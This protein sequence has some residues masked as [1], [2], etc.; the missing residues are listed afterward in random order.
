MLRRV[1]PLRRAEI[2][3]PVLLVCSDDASLLERARVLVP[4]A[5]QAGQRG[6]LVE[7]AT[8]GASVLIDLRRGGGHEAGSVSTLRCEPALV[9]L[10]I[11]ALVSDDD[12][13][14]ARDALGAGASDFL[15]DGWLERDLVP[16]LAAQQNAWRTRDELRLRERD[17][18]TLVELTRSFAGALDAGA[19]LHD[20]T[21]R[22]AEELALRRCS[23]V[24]TDAR[25]ERGTVVATSDD[26]AIARRSIEL[27]KYP[28]IREA[29]RTR[30]AVVVHDAGRH[31]LLDPVKE[32]VSAAGMGAMAV[33]PLALEEEIL[34][35]LFLRTPAG[36][37]RSF[38]SRELDFAAAVANATAVALRN[39]R[40]VAE[41]RS[42]VREA[43]EQAAT[44]R[45]YE[46]IYEHV[47]DGIALV[48]RSS[49]RLRS[50]N[51]AALGI[52]GLD[53]EAVRGRPM[54]ELL[55]AA[56]GTPW[57][58]LVAGASAGGMVRNVEFPAIR[59]DGPEVHLAVS[60][61]SLDEELV[62]L[63]IRDVTERKRV[64]QELQ[65]TRENLEKRTMIVELAGAA[66][67]ELNQPLTSV[68]GWAELLQ[69]RLTE[70][71][72]AQ[73][74]VS[75]ILREAERMAEVVRKIGNITRHET[76]AYVGN[77]RILD[78]EKAAG[79]AEEGET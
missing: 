61:S 5:V 11:L 33:L 9:E 59:S 50:A 25:G 48:D 30:R 19:L 45:R 4:L 41:I 39:A 78:L 15:R 2:E 47:S 7:R 26:E 64:E 20:V 1:S 17:L 10:P 32:A 29:L 46:E 63:A 58:A 68:L 60:A 23:L 67:H 16:R 3:K 75:I 14:A 56:E 37:A 24:L 18:H 73:R 52:L 40:S 28:E 49:G 51:P 31:P 34:G 74:P 44:L 38:S 77:A 66:A 43:E 71:D 69:R 72:A 53:A 22:L 8:V 65:R 70:G 12:D 54:G 21:R 62:V 36:P 35:V 27:A 42:R 76:R 13:A 6:T 55:R 79:G 57:E